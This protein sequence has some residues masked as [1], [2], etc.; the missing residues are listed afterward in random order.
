MRFFLSSSREVFSMFA[1]NAVTGHYSYYSEYSIF[2]IRY[3]WT[4]IQSEKLPTQPGFEPGSLI[5]ILQVV[6]SNFGRDRIKK[7]KK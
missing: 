7:I 5:W 1:L 2:P 3:G 4:L 6:R